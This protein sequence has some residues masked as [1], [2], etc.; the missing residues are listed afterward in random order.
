MSRQITVR[1][2]SED[3]HHR[4]EEVSRSRGTSVNQTVLSIL[5]SALAS[6]ERRRRL[7]RYATWTREDLERFERALAP[8]RQ[9]DDEAWR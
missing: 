8:Q 2:L 3:L 5:E 6:N 1:K 4:L 7:E 9:V